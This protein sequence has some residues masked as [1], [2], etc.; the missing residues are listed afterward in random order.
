MIH[1]RGMGI[2]ALACVVAPSWVAADVVDSSASGFTVKETLTIQ[3]APQ[4]VY[5]KIFQVSDWWNPA[6]TFSNDAHN[7]SLEEKVGGCFCEKLP[8]GGGVKHM[9]VVYVSPATAIVLHGTL[10]PLQ[11]VAATGSMQIQL[12]RADTGTKVEVT[13]TVGGY[14]AAGLNTWA[15]PVDGVLKEQFTRLKN[16]MEK[17]DPAAK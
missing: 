16:S 2:L 4:D 8:T 15:G 13:Y 10:G 7:L 11:S 14:L 5:S 9:E 12:T 3:K 6:H 1:G 17:G